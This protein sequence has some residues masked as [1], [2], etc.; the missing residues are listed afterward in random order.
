MDDG[1]TKSSPP[2]RILQVFVPVE[3]KE[4]AELG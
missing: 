1:S 3:V 4:L 2:N